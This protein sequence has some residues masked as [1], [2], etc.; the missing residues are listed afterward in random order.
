MRKLI[1]CTRDKIIVSHFVEKELRRMNYAYLPEIIIRLCLLYYCAKDDWNVKMCHSIIHISGAF[2]TRLSGGLFE[3]IGYKSVFLEN[4]VGNGIHVWQFRIRN[5]TYFD[6]GIASTRQL[7]DSTLICY[8]FS[9]RHGQKGIHY[10]SFGIN[11]YCITDDMYTYV[12]PLDLIGMKVDFYASVITY[13]V[14]NVK[15][16]EQRFCPYN[17]F[18]QLSNKY[19]AGVTLAN[20][21]DAIELISYQVL[22]DL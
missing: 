18:M 2:V 17:W 8:G 4:M 9:S 1:I 12:K 21:G 11:K 22:S 6:L 3:D 7:L 5:C 10:H 15:V 19:H 14:N 13:S 20:H 16:K